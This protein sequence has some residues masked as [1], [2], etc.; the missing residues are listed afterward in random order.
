[1]TTT[2]HAI[3]PVSVKTTGK[4][5]SQRQKDIETL[6]IP[7]ILKIEYVMLDDAPTS[8]ENELD[9][10]LCVFDLMRKAI[11]VANKGSAGIFVDCMC[12]PGVK[13]LRTLVDIPVIGAAET[14]FHTAASLSHKFSV[15]DI[16][17][18]TAPMVEALIQ[19]YG[20]G[21]SFASVRGTGG[22]VEEIGKNDTLAQLKEQALKAVEEDHA[23]FIV[24]GCTGFTGYDKALEQFLKSKKHDVSVLDPRPLGLRMLGAI[25]LQ[26]LRHSKKAW[27]TP[28]PE[29]KK[30]IGFESDILQRFYAD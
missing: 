4:S 11:D 16:G 19:K 30:L 21:Q 17:D 23:D 27:P 8:I 5:L 25:A 10:A 13:V 24:L 7:D 29:H 3:C 26:G 9:D 14:A 12:D 22:A 20:L 28:K 15:V 18:D 1:M 2:I 6:Q